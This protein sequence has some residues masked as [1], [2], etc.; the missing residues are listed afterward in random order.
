[1]SCCPAL[2]KPPDRV[3]HLLVWPLGVSSSSPPFNPLQSLFFWNLGTLVTVGG[4]RRSE[5]PIERAELQSGQGWGWRPWMGA[6][7]PMVRASHSHF[8]GLPSSSRAH[9]PGGMCSLP[10]G[11][12]K[13]RWG[14]TLEVNR[15]SPCPQPLIQS[16]P[17]AF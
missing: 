6:Y 16:S 4:L 10:G 11:R 17:G 15:S 14:G 9:P 7:A 13:S 2:S 12:R 3:Y 5:P 8:Q 1:M